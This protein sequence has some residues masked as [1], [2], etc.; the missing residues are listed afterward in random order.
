[1][2]RV[3]NHLPRLNITLFTRPHISTFLLL[4]IISLF[5]FGLVIVDILLRF[6]YNVMD[7]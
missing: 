4:L 3:E 5:V 6:F 7:E 2:I 1:M